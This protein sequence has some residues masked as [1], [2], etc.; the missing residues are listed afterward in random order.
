MGSR[1]SPRS[2]EAH[3]RSRAVYGESVSLARLVDVSPL[4]FVRAGS[5]KLIHK[6]VPELY[7]LVADPAE[8]NNL[9]GAEPARA[10]QMRHGLAQLLASRREAPAAAGGEVDAETQ[11]R[12]ESLGYLVA[13]SPS[14]NDPS[15]D[16]I[17][18][19][20]P[21]P[22][23]IAAKVEPFVDALGVT[24]FVDAQ[25]TAT[26]VEKLSREFPNSSGILQMLINV[27]LGA[28]LAEGAVTSLKRG[29]AI[30]PDREQYWSNL[31]ELLTRLGR[32]REAATT[33]TETLRRWPCD[34]TSRT[35]LANVYSRTGARAK[36]IE[37]LEQGI[38]KCSSP[39]ALMNDLAYQLA[40]VPAA[41]LRD[42]KRALELAE[43]MIGSLGD[44]PLA[45]DTLAVAQAAAGRRDD[46]RSTISRALTMA[47][48]QNMPDVAL[49]LLRAHAGKIAA[50]Q[51]IRE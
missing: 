6:P 12:L 48:Q 45:L 10:E 30:D 4:R 43:S 3:C 5:W 36:Q 29:I 46:A 39:P 49:S 38:E 33:L 31:G 14:G 13:G 21:D 25:Q 8:A 51:P 7:D 11:R 16:A 37:V 24:Q 50:G 26:L 23:L 32:D 1:C 41:P 42:G 15:L 27:Q 35:H 18:V 22:T 44:N 2:R 47:E 34:L 17:A 9:A 20:G 19:H 28:G 40:T